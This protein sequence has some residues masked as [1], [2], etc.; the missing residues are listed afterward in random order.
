MPQLQGVIM[1]FRFMLGTLAAMLLVVGVASAKVESAEEFLQIVQERVESGVLTA[2]DALLL[3]FHYAFDRDQ[4]PEEL[5]PEG[6]APMKCGTVLIMEL[7]QM[8]GSLRS[9]AL[10]TIEAY[11]AP[12]NDPALATYISPSGIFR[13]TY[14]TSGSH[15]VPAGD[16]NSNGIPDWVERM[17]EYADYVWDF[18]I[19]QLGFRGP[20]VPSSFTYY[21]ISIES[22]SGIY[23]YCTVVNYAL[24]MT[25]IVLHNNYLG[26]PPNDDPDG[27]ALGAAK[28]TIAHE[29]KHASQFMT[30][31]WSESDWV[32][33]DATWMEEIAYP[34]TNDYLNYLSSGSPIS[35]P[36]ITLNG[37]YEDCV[38]QLY[39]S[40]THGVPFIV[41]FWEWRRTNQSQTV[42][43]SY[44]QILINYGSDLITAWNEFT[45]WNYAS[46][47][48]WLPTE[49]YAEGNRYPTGQLQRQITSYPHTWSS[50]VPRL[51]ANF[52]R[53]TNASTPGETLRVTF[54]GAAGTRW[55]LS[56][57]VNISYFYNTGTTFL[58]PLVNDDSAEWVLPY[59]LDGVYSVGFV[60]GNAN[61]IGTNSSYTITVEKVP[62]QATSVADMPQAL[63]ITGN[64]PNPFNPS[65]NIRFALTDQGHTELDVVDLSGRKVRTLVSGNLL[66]G[67]HTV[68]WNGQDDLGRS[69]PSGTYI[70]HLRSG[71]Q[72]ASHKL[73]LTK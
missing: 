70:A 71:D 16:A 27:H 19:D 60:V 33:G 45:T 12:R 3:K 38:W 57:V 41:D 20:P 67:D 40:E 1:K 52:I 30:S 49:S 59:D 21:E 63:A 8:R 9:D 22:L 31:R 68:L 25:R 29:F 36:N 37:L 15:A 61:K 39:L 46:G 11:I 32:E 73:V 18:E 64:H 58:V 65:T 14:Q 5:Q 23:G 6:V 13:I 2:E 69:L 66:S 53:C 28:V 51:A 54:N 7:E 43:N 4:L 62:Y 72:V 35:N 55:T 17:A 42:I 26:F 56:A 50:T 24:G 47:V 34:E 10:E 44:E 48:R